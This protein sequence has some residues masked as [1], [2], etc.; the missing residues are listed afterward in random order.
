M[1]QLHLAMRVSYNLFLEISAPTFCK[2]ALYIRI[3]TLLYFYYSTSW[4]DLECGIKINKLFSIDYKIII[5]ER[6]THT[7]I[8]VMK[9]SKFCWINT[10]LSLQ[11][12]TT[13]ILYQK[14]QTHPVFAYHV[15]IFFHMNLLLATVGTWSKSKC[16]FALKQYSHSVLIYKHSTSTSPALVLVAALSG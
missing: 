2:S 5:P 11:K 8:T 4:W 16:T 12:L 15:H 3:S 6:E 7:C 9:I 10:S 13:V 14:W 1:G